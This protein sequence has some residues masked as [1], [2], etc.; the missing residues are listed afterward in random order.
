MNIIVWNC[1]GLTSKVQEL[2]IL[3]KDG[4]VICL[5][6]TK[7]RPNSYY[8][9]FLKGFN[10]I[11]QDRV[12]GEGGGLLVFLKNSIIY[13]RINLQNIPFGVEVIGVQIKNG[14]DAIHLF[15][16][17][18]PPRPEVTKIQLEAFI[19]QLEGYPNTI[20]SGDFNA[21]HDLWGSSLHNP[22][23]NYLFD[24]L[25]NSQLKPLNDGEATGLHNVR[26]SNSIPDITMVSPDLAIFTKWDTIKDPLRSDHYPI[27]LQVSKGSLIRGEVSHRIGL[28]KVDW[29]K[30]SEDLAIYCNSRP[31]LEENN[32]I[33]EYA[34][35]SPKE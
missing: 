25:L 7:L 14:N 13:S 32:Y 28:S 6:E 15:S 22:R 11:R 17:Y 12:T 35:N 8:K 18:I 9:P 4:D 1:R 23:G 20:I 19:P 27:L 5:S 29:S 30:F 31:S 16:V 2:P 34:R 33:Q 26:G 3:T 24:I 21:H 10:H